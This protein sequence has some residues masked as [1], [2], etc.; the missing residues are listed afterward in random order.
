MM[1]DGVI[2]GHF[3]DAVIFLE[4][5]NRSSLL[6][7]LNSGLHDKV[8]IAVFMDREYRKTIA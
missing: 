2:G 1:W 3:E 5:E 4:E 6:W 7:G 8:C